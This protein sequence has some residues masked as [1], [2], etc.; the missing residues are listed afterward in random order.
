MF[1][2]PS[3]RMSCQGFLFFLSFFKSILISIF[4][5]IYLFFLSPTDFVFLWDSWTWKQIFL[6]LEPFVLSCSDLSA[7]VFSYYILLL[8]L[9]DCFLMGDRK[10]ADP[11]GREGGEELG[12]A[13]SVE[14]IIRLH[15]MEKETIFNKRKEYTVLIFQRWTSGH[16]S[17]ECFH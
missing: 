6:F 7:F 15:C 11:G 4:T 13:E 5:F 12:E 9:G 16:F 1:G 17:P 8:S 14:T 2:I 10:R 3:L